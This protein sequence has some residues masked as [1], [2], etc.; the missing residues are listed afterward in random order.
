MQVFRD[1]GAEGKNDNRN[2]AGSQEQ[3]AKKMGMLEE[4][5]GNLRQP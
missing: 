2:E 5:A 4:K 3:A 1:P